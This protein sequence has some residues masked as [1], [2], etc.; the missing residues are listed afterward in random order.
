MHGSWTCFYQISQN[1]RKTLLNQASRLKCCQENIFFWL[2]RLCL[3]IKYSSENFCFPQKMV[4]SP[5]GLKKK[6]SSSWKK[7]FPEFS[8]SWC[9]F[10]CQREHLF[11]LQKIELLTKQFIQ[12]W[13]TQE[14]NCSGSSKRERWLCRKSWLWQQRS[15]FFLYLYLVLCYQNCSDLL[16]EKNVLVI[17]KKNEIRG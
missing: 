6:Y 14:K 16:W 10:Y 2:K 11:L 9:N 17:E 3:E 1:C 13:E 5:Q 8:C 4:F 15:I 7:F 12:F